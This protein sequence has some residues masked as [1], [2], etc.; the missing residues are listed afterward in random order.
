MG[1]SDDAEIEQWTWT[2]TAKLMWTLAPFQAVGFN[3]RLLA[4]TEAA[5]SPDT[6]G[7]SARR[8]P[9]AGYARALHPSSER[10]ARRGDASSFDTQSQARQ[11]STYRALSSW[12]DRERY[13][14]APRESAEACM[15]YRAAR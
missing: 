10:S 3:F 1:Y 15:E 4:S 2:E 6:R 14:H 13:P 11:T 8:I 12:R 7:Q 9:Q 5:Q